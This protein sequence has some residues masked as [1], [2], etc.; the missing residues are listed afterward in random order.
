MRGVRQQRRRMH[1]TFRCRLTAGA[2]AAVT[3]AASVALLVV[4]AGPAAAEVLPAGFS[5][6]AEPTGSGIVVEIAHAPDGRR[7]VA[8]KGGRVKVLH[9]DGRVTPLLDLRNKVN[10][11]SDRG[12]LGLAVDNDFAT[13]G[14]LY[15]LFSQ[16]AD[17]AADGPGPMT[18]ALTRVAVRAD[19]TVAKPTSPGVYIL[20]GQGEQPCPTPADT[21]DCM[22]SRPLHGTAIGTVRSRH[23]RTGRCGSA[24]GDATY[25][26]AGDDH[27]T[28]R[29]AGRARPTAGKILHIDQRRHGSLAG[30]PFCPGPSTDLTRDLHEGVRRGASATR[31]CFT[32]RPG[33]GPVAGD[34][35]QDAHEEI[36]LDPAGRQ[37]R[38]AV[39]RGSRP[40]VRSAR[41]STSSCEAL[42]AQGGDRRRRR[43]R[44]RG[45]YGHARERRSRDRWA[46]RS[47]A[48]PGYPVGHASASI[49]VVRL[50]AGLGEAPGGLNDAG[51]RRHGRPRLRDG[52]DRRLALRNSSR[53]HRLRRHGPEGQRPRR[54]HLPVRRGHERAPDR[55]GDAHPAERCGASR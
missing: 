48:G 14:W 18:S 5:T 43:P 21:L 13:N 45:G 4:P 33:K 38:L 50:R 37:L 44:R 32:L 28:L 12:L 20:G 19:S 9:Q 51:R 49:F 3:L 25:V 17:S 24:P 8:E 26:V 1:G 34:V 6:A 7:F 47:T 15:L 53:E 11:Y 30:H 36:D 16:E 31:S 29:H 40:A 22:P 27:Q 55:C 39:L 42:Y 10:D 35:G 41:A 2:S 54:G 23:R 46:A 52:L